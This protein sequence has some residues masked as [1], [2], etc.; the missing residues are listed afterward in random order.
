MVYLLQQFSCLCRY[1]ISLISIYTLG[2]LG[3]LSNLTGSL[4]LANE[5]Y[6]SPTEWI[7]RKPN[8]KKMAG[9]NSRFGIDF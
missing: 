5:H 8:K 1:S 2:D 7:M 9:V 3:I 6:S 4:S